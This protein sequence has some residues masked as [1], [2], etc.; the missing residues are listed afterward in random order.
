LSFISSLTR[1]A[2]L[3]SEIGC[4]SLEIGCVS[5]EIG[6]DHWRY[7]KDH[8]KVSKAYRPSLVGGIGWQA[9]AISLQICYRCLVFCGI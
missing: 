1:C 7:K 6:S 3:L 9:G 4:V 5:L 2:A 8:R